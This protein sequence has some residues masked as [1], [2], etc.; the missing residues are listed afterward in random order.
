MYKKVEGAHTGFLIQFTGKR[1]QRIGDGTWETP[2]AEVVWKESVMK[3]AMTYICRR[4][5]TVAHWVALRPIF[6]LCAGEKG[7]EGVG[8]RTESCWRQ[9]AT[10]KQL[11]DTLAGVSGEAERRRRL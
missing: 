5:A 11:R 3:L 9:E 2:G 4:Q 1:A 10:K 8:H 6:D 7:Y